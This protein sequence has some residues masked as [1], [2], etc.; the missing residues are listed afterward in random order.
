M[1][2]PFAKHM[3]RRHLRMMLSVLYGGRSALGRQCGQGLQ[4][5]ADLGLV[6][7]AVLLEVLQSALATRWRS[8]RRASSTICTSSSNRFFHQGLSG[9]RRGLCHKTLQIIPDLAGH[10]RPQFCL[11]LRQAGPHP[12]V[13]LARAR[14]C[15]V[16]VTEAVTDACRSVRSCSISTPCAGPSSGQGRRHPARTRTAA[17]AVLR[18][19]RKK[20]N[21]RVE[22]SSRRRRLPES[23]GLVVP[24]EDLR[25]KAVH[26]PITPRGQA[27][28]PG[29]R[30]TDGFLL[31]GFRLS[32]TGDDRQLWIRMSTPIVL[33]MS[34]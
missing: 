33:S 5:H 29:S 15:T 23:A 32:Q 6:A 14:S 10:L 16:E 2:M 9:I 8:F 30:D 1:I 17:T 12:L 4:S 28:D 3:R 21:T 19:P 31:H 27:G 20:G 11:I 22:P 25:A 7:Q 18:K 24:L 34:P 26:L 13:D